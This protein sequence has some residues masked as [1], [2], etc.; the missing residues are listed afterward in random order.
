[1]NQFTSTLICATAALGLVCGL[2]RSAHAQSLPP[3]DCGTALARY[4]GQCVTAYTTGSGNYGLYADA[5]SA[6]GVYA[7]SANGNGVYGTVGTSSAGVY[8]NNTS[9]GDG[10]IGVAGSGNGVY[11][12]STGTGVGVY[13]GNSGTGYAGYF[14]GST[15]TTGC[16][17]YN[18]TNEFGCSSDRRLKQNIAPLT[19]ALNT[20]LRLKG[21]TYDWKKPEEQGKN[22]RMRQTGFIAQDVEGVFPNW[23]DE[24]ADGYKTLAIQ[25]AQVTALEVESIRALKLQNDLLTDRVK[26]LESGRRPRVSASTS[27]ASASASAA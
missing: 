10:V 24:N 11:G 19:D 15:N 16:I 17:Q 12:L 8:G 9:T 23:V 26:E 2:S 4:S 14:H 6:D 25:P 21:V 18:G 5:A 27:T 13:G 7:T 1:M 20:L 3:F 22:A